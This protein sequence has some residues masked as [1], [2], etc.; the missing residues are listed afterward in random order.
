[1]FFQGYGA[2]VRNTI[3]KSEIWLMPVPPK[4]ESPTLYSALGWRDLHW[5]RLFTSRVLTGVRN[6]F[7]DA[8]A[9]PLTSTTDP[10]A[11]AREIRAPYRKEDVA[12]LFDQEREIEFLVDALQRLETL[13]IAAAVARAQAVLGRAPRTV[14]EAGIS[15]EFGRQFRIEAQDSAVKIVHAEETWT[16]QRRQR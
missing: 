9:L 8:G 11:R 12:R 14:E 3:L 2:I 16:L 10:A 1:V 13:R 4:N 5:K 7:R 6:E 15:S